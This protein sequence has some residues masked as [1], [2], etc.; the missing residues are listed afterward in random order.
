MP[1]WDEE[2]YIKIALIVISPCICL[3]CLDKVNPCYAIL[4]ILAVYGYYVLII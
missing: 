3:V 1:N 2:M 4:Y